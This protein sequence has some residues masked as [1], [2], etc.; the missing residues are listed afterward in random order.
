MLTTWQ[1]LESPGDKPLDSPVKDHLDQVNC[2][3]KTCPGCGEH[4]PTGSVLGCTKR[5]KQ[6]EHKH[7]LLSTVSLDVTWP[8]ASSSGFPG[9]PAMVDCPPKTVSQN[10]HPLSCFLSKG[11]I[12]ETGREGPAMAISKEVVGACCH[13][14]SLTLEQR[15]TFAHYVSLEGLSEEDSDTT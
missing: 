7:F 1:D 10:K 14:K 9:F 8:V 12:T 13:E 11:C 6:P 4:P 2:S 3:G 15:C 5:R